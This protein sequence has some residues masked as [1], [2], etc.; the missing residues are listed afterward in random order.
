MRIFSRCVDHT[1]GDKRRIRFWLYRVTVVESTNTAKS[2][3][4]HRGSASVYLL[5]T[6]PL[7]LL[8]TQPHS[9]IYAYDSI[10]EQ[11]GVETQICDNERSR[12]SHHWGFWW[13]WRHNGH[14]TR[15]TLLHIPNQSYGSPL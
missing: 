8:P 12:G 7:L 6:T 13:H 11:K 5:C 9:R 4:L 14:A 2:S 10:L 1:E 15:H 3:S